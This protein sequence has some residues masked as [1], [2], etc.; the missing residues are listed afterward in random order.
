[1]FTSSKFVHTI[2]KFVHTVKILFT[3]L[4][5]FYTIEIFVRTMKFWFT[6]SQFYSHSKMELFTPTIFIHTMQFLFTLARFYSNHEIYVFIHYSSLVRDG[7]TSPHSPRLVVSRSTC[8]PI[9]SHH[10]SLFHTIP[11]LTGTRWA[12]HLFGCYYVMHHVAQ[13]SYPPTG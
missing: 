6:L 13:C 5:L 10:A 1:M 11:G 9:S 2:K 4:R 8:P 3:L 7:Q 12:M